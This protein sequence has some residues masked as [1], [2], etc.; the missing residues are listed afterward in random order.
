MIISLADAP[1]FGEEG[2]ASPSQNEP[3]LKAAIRNDL[4]PAPVSPNLTL[5]GRN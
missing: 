5:H 2:T 1:L 3:A 4:S